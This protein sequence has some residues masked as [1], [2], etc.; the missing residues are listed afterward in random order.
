MVSILKT[1]LSPLCVWACLK[2]VYPQIHLCII[3]Y[4]HFFL[5]KLAFLGVHTHHSQGHFVHLIRFTP[6]SRG[7]AI[8]TAIQTPMSMYNALCNEA[9]LLFEPWHFQTN[10]W[11]GQTHQMVSGPDITGQSTAAFVT[12][13]YYEMNG[14][15]R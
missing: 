9:L 10:R 15:D 4:H 2:V 3:M 13:F 6:N 14:Y 8:W 5:Y 12:K 11:S 7:L 1:C